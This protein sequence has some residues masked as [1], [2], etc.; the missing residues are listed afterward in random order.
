MTKKNVKILE[1]LDISDYG[2]FT[3]AL[4]CDNENVSHSGCAFM[5]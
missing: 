5:Y 2:L 1:I 4:T 3:T